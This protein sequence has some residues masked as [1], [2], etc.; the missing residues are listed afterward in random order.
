MCSRAI[1]QTYLGVPEDLVEWETFTR[2]LLSIHR[3]IQNLCLHVSAVVRPPGRFYQGVSARDGT[4]VIKVEVA[5]FGDPCID[6]MLPYL[7]HLCRSRNP[8]EAAIYIQRGPPHEDHIPSGLYGSVITGDGLPELNDHRFSGMLA[9]TMDMPF[10]QRIAIYLNN[11]GSGPRTPR[12]LRM[13]LNLYGHSGL[14]RLRFEIDGGLAG[15]LHCES[16][17]GLGVSTTLNVGGNI[18]L[19]RLFASREL[20]GSTADLSPYMIT[21]TRQPSAYNYIIGVYAVILMREHDGLNSC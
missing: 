12:G 10:L 8:R 19:P 20:T 15:S 21:I 3:C 14:H 2:A 16:A 5:A 13:G 6:F 17:D 7:S 9:A 1:L 4:A 11:T 18:P